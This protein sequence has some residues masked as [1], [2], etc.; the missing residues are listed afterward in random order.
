[1]V[2]RYVT[3]DLELTYQKFRMVH[4]S[5][6]HSLAIARRPSVSICDVGGSWP[7]RLKILE[8][9]CANNCGEVHI[10]IWPS[11]CHCHSLIHL[12]PG[13]HGVILGRKCSFDTYVHNVRLN[14]VKFNRESR[15]LRWRCGWWLFVYFCHRIARSSMQLQSFLVSEDITLI[16][17]TLL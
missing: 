11:I 7:H 9:N 4:Y 6:K 3:C 14:L 17:Q 8:T 10:C 5:A 15:D 12:L 13:E 2:G 1:M 16:D